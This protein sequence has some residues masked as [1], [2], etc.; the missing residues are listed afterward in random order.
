MQNFCFWIKLNNEC[1]NQRY[2]VENNDD[3]CE[4]LKEASWEYDKNRF[5]H[6]KD[7]QT[8]PIKSIE[9]ET[10]NDKENNQLISNT[11]EEVL[12][13]QAF[14]ND[15]S[16]TS[17]YGKSKR[18]LYHLRQDVIVKIIFRCMRKYFIK[19]FKAF[20]DF[21]K[22]RSNN[23]S[24]K[25]GVLYRQINRYLDAK[26]G[27]K[28]LENMAIYFTSIIDIKEK[29]IS[30]SNQHKDLKETISGLL[31]CY[32]KIKLSN[33]I[34]IPQFALLMFSFLN[35]SNILKLV[36]KSQ[37]SSEVIQTYSEVIQTLKCQCSMSL[38]A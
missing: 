10:I 3:W 31:Y 35:K 16:S 7:I 4:E 30:M 13:T 18:K 34:K 6:F 21:S 9:S 11:V 23:N 20:F 33:L 26:F 32:N 8:Y 38:R 1:R 24:D 28:K 15:V 25:N 22:C 14:C 5:T 12:Q 37:D 19:D 36:I 27:D 29:F 2:L 17:N